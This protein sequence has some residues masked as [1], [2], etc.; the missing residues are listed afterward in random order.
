MY[1]WLKFERVF[2]MHLSPASKCLSPAQNAFVSS[3]NSVRLQHNKHVG[4][5]RI[6]TRGKRFCRT[7]FEVGMDSKSTETRQG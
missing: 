4:L 6:E 2:S 7:S 5:D 3:T 1:V